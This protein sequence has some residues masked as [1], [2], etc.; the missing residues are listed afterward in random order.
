[1]P[2]PASLPL[3]SPPV[4]GGEGWKQRARFHLESSLCDLR[5]AFGNGRAVHRA[6]VESH[7]SGCSR[8][9]N[10]ESKPTRSRN[11]KPMKSD[12]IAHVFRVTST[13]TVIALLPAAPTSGRQAASKLRPRT[14]VFAV[15]GSLPQ[16][17]SMPAG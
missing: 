2:I 17:S 4:R 14:F 8:S 6:Q 3:S 10:R 5:N 11:A 12:A 13:T 15:S 7:R 9:I 16:R 1:M